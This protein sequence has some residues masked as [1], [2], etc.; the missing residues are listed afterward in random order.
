MKT[1]IT[2][3]CIAIASTAFAQK[4]DTVMIQTSA[5]CEMCVERITEALKDVRGI[6]KIDHSEENI[7][8]F[9][10]IF[11]N[12]RTNKKTIETA[13]ANR[14][15]DANQMPATQTAYLELPKCCRKPE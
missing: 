2:L 3:I 10:V 11:S 4:I 12:R 13:V 14:G 9:L 5:Q 8:E 7:Q 15:Y 6:K 1:I